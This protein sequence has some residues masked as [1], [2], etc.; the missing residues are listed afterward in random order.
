MEPTQQSIAD[1]VGVSRMTVSRALRN[2]PSIP[3]R[4]RARIRA[5]AARQGYRPDP[6]VSALMTRLRQ[7]RPHKEKPVIAY[8]D[9][10]S[11]DTHWSRYNY[12]RQMREG[13]AARAV[14][15]GYGLEVFNLPGMGIRETKIGKILNARG[16]RGV[17]ISP[18]MENRAFGMDLSQFAAAALGPSIITPNL[19]RVQGHFL[20]I[21][22][23]L[24]ELNALGLRKIG[25][26]L[27]HL[28]DARMEY[29]LAAHVLHYQQ[30]IPEAQR[31]PSLLVEK[32]EREGYLEWIDRHA[33]EAVVGLSHEAGWW[34][35]ARGGP[36]PVVV[37]LNWQ[38]NDGSDYG[39]DQQMELLGSAAVDLV[40]EQMQSNHYGIPEHPKTVLL[41]GRWVESR[42]MG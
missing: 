27:D 3:E 1:A 29:S 39:I 22:Q 13:A 11:P 19:H 35:R 14:A 26:V 30:G 9:M 36:R 33:P 21:R 10:A 12:L 16:I 15:L 41:H 32:I 20:S 37:N 25:L 24:Q 40:V 2:D 31:V 28:Q 42:G 17:V 34:L 18:L 8:L 6:L 4:T 5:E 23:A 7:V 38:R